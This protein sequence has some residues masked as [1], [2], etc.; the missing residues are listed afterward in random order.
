MPR[1]RRTPAL[2]LAMALV[3]ALGACTGSPS[4]ADAPTHQHAETAVTIWTDEAEVFVEHPPMVAGAAGT[5]WAVHLTRLSD[6]K[7]VT[8][9]SLT[10]RFRGQGGQGFM[11]RSEAPAQPGLFVPAPSLPE[12]GVYRV[13]IDVDSPQLTARIDA[14]S[15]TVYA[16]EAEVPH[17]EAVA[18]EATIRFAKEQQWPI[19][20]E[21]AKVALRAVAHTFAVSGTVRPAAGQMAD[22]AAPVSGLLLADANL[23]APAAGD[24]VRQGQT[25]AVIAPAIGDNSYAEAKA[26]VERLQ[27]E[28]AR[29]QRLFDAEAIPEQRLIE[30][31]H[32]LEVAEAAFAAMG[33]SVEAD[34]YNYRVRAPISGVVNARAMVPGARVEAGDRLFTLVNPSV[35]WLR[36]DLPAREAAQANTITE[37]VFTVEGG[38]TLFRTR[39]VVSVGS[40]LDPDTRTLPVTLAVDNRDRRLK[41]GLFAEGQAF[42]GEQTSMGLALP[43]DAIQHEDGQ[44]VA[45]VQIGGEAFERRPLVLGA[46]DGRYTLIERGVEA[47]E[48]VVI[49]G[50]YQVYLASLNTSEISDHGHPH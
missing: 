25:L 28:A 13:I 22:V 33:G 1:L 46:T 14:G 24:A 6:F 8:E 27:R 31:R 29:L 30:A 38:N 11:V 39:R 19:D 41:I 9:G 7:P 5:L 45:Y 18:S 47:G 50:A 40:V 3:A 2:I 16:S 26:R 35:V 44:P 36:L 4:P 32:D 43:N 10:L 48:Y 20:F 15:V 23:R 42:V 37:V 12:P 17:D 21:V 49:A 34:G